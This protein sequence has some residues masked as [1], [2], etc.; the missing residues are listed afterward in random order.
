MGWTASH[1][2]RHARPAAAQQA[3]IC[4]AGPE[5]PQQRYED[6]GLPHLAGLSMAART[7]AV[8]NTSGIAR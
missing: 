6:W 1:T 4:E 5:R 8:T 3:G 2:L 7:V